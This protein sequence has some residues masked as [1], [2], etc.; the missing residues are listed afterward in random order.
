[1][2]VL[3]GLALKTPYHS[4]CSWF[5]VR[6]NDG[7]VAGSR[8]HNHLQSSGEHNTSSAHSKSTLSVSPSLAVL[9]WHRVMTILFPCGQGRG[10]SRAMREEVGSLGQLGKRV[11]SGIGRGKRVGRGGSGRVRGVGVHSGV[12]RRIAVLPASLHCSLHWAIGA[13]ICSLLFLQ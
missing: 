6:D 5:G 2:N 9:S 8:L 13:V 10:S 3:D 7:V 4:E 1:M 12:G 11:N